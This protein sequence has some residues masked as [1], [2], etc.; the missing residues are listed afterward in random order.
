MHFYWC[1]EKTSA[2]VHLDSLSSGILLVRLVSGDIFYEGKGQSV[3]KQHS[4]ERILSTSIDRRTKKH[5]ER[6]RPRRRELTKISSVE[7]S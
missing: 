1:Q 6:V 7:T 3:Q 5:T 2:D 4:L